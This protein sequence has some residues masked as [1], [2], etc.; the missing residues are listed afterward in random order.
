MENCYDID[1]IINSLGRGGAERVCVSLANEMTNRNYKVRIIVLRNISKNYE[2]D[3]NDNIQIYHLNA[4]KDLFGI[5]K[6]KK[7]LKSGNF[8]KIVAFDERITSICNYVKII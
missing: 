2:S 7:I 4:K 5:L 6:L 1:F 8:K 3:V